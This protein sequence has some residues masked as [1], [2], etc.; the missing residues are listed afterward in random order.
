MK[1]AIN[2]VY[3]RNVINEMKYLQL[4]KLNN[5]RASNAIYKSASKKETSASIANI[6]G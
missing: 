6:A 3:H 1:I 5:Q 2:E 4:N